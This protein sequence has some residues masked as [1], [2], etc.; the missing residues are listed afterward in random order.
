M[1]RD[2]WPSVSCRP[3]GARVRLK[4]T[5]TVRGRL[6][7]HVGGT[8]GE[9]P[10]ECI[11]RTDVYESLSHQFYVHFP[12]PVRAVR[13]DPLDGPG[14]FRLENFC[15][16]PV[17]T[18]LTWWYA[19]WGKL[20]LLAAHDGLIARSLGRG[21]RLLARGEFRL[22]AHKLFRGLQPPSIIGPD[23]ANL[24]ADYQTWCRRRQLFDTD[25]SRMRGRPPPGKNRRS[26][27]C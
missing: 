24:N 12:E 18:P 7:L 16:E 19:F 1:R 13:L 5:S 25:R 4:M 21:L 8:E 2:S 15:I 11:E 26:S 17:L 10:A 3:V 9:P 27:P 23:Y 22:F 14:R 20:D 6:S